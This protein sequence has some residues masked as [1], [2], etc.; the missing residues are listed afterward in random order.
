MTTEHKIL[1]LIDRGMRRIDDIERILGG[2]QRTANAIWT[3]IESSH[4]DLCSIGR[5]VTLTPAGI[6]RLNDLDQC[7][8]ER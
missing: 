7:R 3:A 2:R 4:A 6:E 1:T 8:L 5:D